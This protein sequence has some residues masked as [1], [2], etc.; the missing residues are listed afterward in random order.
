MTSTGDVNYFQVTIPANR[1][2]NLSNGFSSGYKML[3]T[4]WWNGGSIQQLSPSFS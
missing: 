3:I 4:Q 2:T 1:L